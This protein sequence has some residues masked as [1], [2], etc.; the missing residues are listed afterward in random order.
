MSCKPSKSNTITGQCESR[1]GI[2][3]PPPD[4]VTQPL[5]GRFTGLHRH[6]MRRFV[7]SLSLSIVMVASGCVKSVPKY[8]HES[9]D[10]SYYLDQATQ[11]DYPDV[12]AVSL[13]EVNQA[14]PPMTVIDPDF[15]NYEDIGLEDAISYALQNGK[16]FRGYGTPSLQGTRVSPGQ[17]NLSNGPT[18][19]GT[20]PSRRP[21]HPTSTGWVRRNT[22]PRN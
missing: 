15:D 19:A 8:L 10:L 14:L 5:S 4:R 13:E 11:I 9:G 20:A 16:V 2:D 18:A 1:F 7:I 17:D 21:R 3:T 6:P 12:E 22:S